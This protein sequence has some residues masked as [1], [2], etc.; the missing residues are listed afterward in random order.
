MKYYIRGPFE[1]ESFTPAF[2]AMVQDPDKII[3]I[4]INSPGGDLNSGLEAY[5]KVHECKEQGKKIVTYVTAEAAS[6]GSYLAWMGDEIY[7]SPCSS[8]MFHKIQVLHHSLW[9]KITYHV[10]KAVDKY[11]HRLRDDIVMCN[12]IL[13]HYAPWPEIMAAYRKK[14]PDY[15]FYFT[16]HEFADMFP[17]RV[18]VGAPPYKLAIWDEDFVFVPEEVLQT[19][20][21]IKDEAIEEEEDD[22]E[23]EGEED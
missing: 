1:G 11:W 10:R 22:E 12:G 9:H 20:E 13:D 4:E 2:D 18:K 19:T 15:D 5:A 7:L 23:E 14:T 21:A 6:A 8:L 3:V 17:R 16:A